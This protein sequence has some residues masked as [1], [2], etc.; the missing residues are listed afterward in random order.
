MRSPAAIF[1]WCEDDHL[2][3]SELESKGLKWFLSD[4]YGSPWFTGDVTKKVLN[5]TGMLLIRICSSEVKQQRVTKVFFTS[6]TKSNFQFPSSPFTHERT[7]TLPF[8]KDCFGSSALMTQ[9]KCCK[10]IF[11]PSNPTMQRSSE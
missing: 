8:V 3:Q 10:H 4:C 6:E 11:L 7:I 1:A 5:I 9:H 2:V